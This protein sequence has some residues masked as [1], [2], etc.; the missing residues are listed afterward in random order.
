MPCKPWSI[1]T[2]K[3]ANA[4]WVRVDDKA[5]DITMLAKHTPSITILYGTTEIASIGF[6]Y[7]K[8]IDCGIIERIM[9]RDTSE[10][11]I[12]LLVKNNLVNG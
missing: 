11:T 7:N 9:I 6:L 1:D 12:Q 4:N 3:Q 2:A 5:N 10:A 8:Y